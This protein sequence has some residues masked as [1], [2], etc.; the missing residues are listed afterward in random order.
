MAYNGLTVKMTSHYDERASLITFKQFIG[1]G[2]GFFASFLPLYI[3][4]YFGGGQEGWRVTALLMAILVIALFYTS[5][6]GSKNRD[7]SI[8]HSEQGREKISIGSYL[9]IL[10]QNKPLVALMVC[11]SCF[12]FSVTLEGSTAIYFFIYYLNHESAFPIY[13]GLVLSLIHI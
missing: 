5:W 8:N 11:Q 7:G 6:F 4:N 10:K 2:V 13:Q 3:S 9:T 1:I 12:M